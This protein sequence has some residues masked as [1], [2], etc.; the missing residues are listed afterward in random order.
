MKLRRS[1]YASADLRNAF[2]YSRAEHGDAGLKRYRALIE[3]ALREIV[4]DPFRPT[5]RDRTNVVQGLRSY[6]IKHSRARSPEKSVR[7]P[8]HI[9]Y[10]RVTQDADNADA[11]TLLRVLQ[12]TW[13]P[14]AR[15]FRDDD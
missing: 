7:A 11:V 14:A 1:P 10:Y 15:D 12:D 2:R 13:E 4:A 8:C 9:L 6:H 3:T 5:S